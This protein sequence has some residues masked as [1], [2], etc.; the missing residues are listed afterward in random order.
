MSVHWRYLQV[1]YSLTDTGRIIQKIN[2]KRLT[3]MRRKIRRL[4][5][6]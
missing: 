2:P 5:Y 6:D 1:Q 3:A 4:N